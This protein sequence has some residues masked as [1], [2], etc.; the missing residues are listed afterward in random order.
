MIIA[1]WLMFAL[2][3]IHIL[4]GLM[5]FKQPVSAAIREGW[6][7][8]IQISDERRLAFWFLIFGPLLMGCGHI[9]IIAAYAHDLAQI[10]VI[11]IY[12]FIIALIGISAVPKSPF[13]APLFLGP[14]FIAFGFGW[15]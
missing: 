13:W 10:K 9:A 15:I 7:G 12:M 6:I 3:I 1:A 5:R 11:G 2:G 14:V 8:K 4:F